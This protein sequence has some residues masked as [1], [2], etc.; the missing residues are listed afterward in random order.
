MQTSQL[1]GWSREESALIAQGMGSRGRDGDE[2]DGAEGGGGEGGDSAHAVADNVDEL[3]YEQWFRA[4]SMKKW[5]GKPGLCCWV[6]AL[7]V[8]VQDKR[9][10]P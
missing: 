10:C 4:A 2:E 3:A 8:R 7:S 9:P 5:F 6:S 1:E